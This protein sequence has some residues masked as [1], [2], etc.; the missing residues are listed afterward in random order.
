MYSVKKYHYKTYILPM[1]VFLLG[2][3]ILSVILHHS[4][5][6]NQK[7]MRTVTELNAEAYSERLQNDINRGI[8]ITDTLEEIVIRPDD[9]LHSKY[10]DRTRRSRYGNLSRNRKRNWQDRPDQ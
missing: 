3:L 8:T 1:L 7:H 9:Q 4:C 5:Q 6:N 10:P 2:C